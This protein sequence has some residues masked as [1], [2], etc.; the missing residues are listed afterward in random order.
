MK[1]SKKMTLS[2]NW[3]GLM[4]FAFSLKYSNIFSIKL[5]LVTVPLSPMTMQLFLARETA[6]LSLRLSDKN[7][8]VPS[9]FDRTR[10]RM[11]TSASPPWYPSTVRTDTVGPTSFA[12]SCTCAAY[13][14]IIAIFFGFIPA[15]IKI[16]VVKVA[17]RAS[18]GLDFFQVLSYKFQ[19]GISKQTEKYQSFRD[20][21]FACLASRPPGT[22]SGKCSI[23]W[24]PR[25]LDWSSLTW[26]SSMLLPTVSIK[27]IG[28]LKIHFYL[29]Q[30]VVVQI[31]IQ[32]QC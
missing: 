29:F 6:T 20:Q 8:V 21:K 15:L 32:M 18:P 14:E 3:A 28:E 1:L 9:I 23:D 4:R 24:Q 30:G 5:S 31:K 10:E 25:T 11:T 16:F 13:G 22:V 2:W 19:F 26:S 12:M 7:P 27:V 17:K